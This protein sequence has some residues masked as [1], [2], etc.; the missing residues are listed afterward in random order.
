MMVQYTR[1]GQVKVWKT[2]CC[3][4]GDQRQ[5]IEQSVIMHARANTYGH[6]YVATDRG[7]YDDITD[8]VESK[9]DIGGLAPTG[10]DGIRTS[11]QRV[12]QKWDAK[13]VSLL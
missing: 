6:M 7:D 11:L 12:H 3:Y 13:S 4:A 5:G 1:S 8:L 2:D 10:E 9:Q